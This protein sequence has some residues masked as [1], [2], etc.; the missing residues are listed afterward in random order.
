MMYPSLTATSYIWREVLMHRRSPSH[1]RLLIVVLLVGITLSSGGPII[2]VSALQGAARFAGSTQSGPVAL[3]ADSSL[4]A[5]ANTDSN[6][7][8]LFDVGGDKNQSLGEIPVGKEPQGVAMTPDGSFVYVANTL[9]GTVSVLKV[10]RNAKPPATV[11]A[12]LQ[13]GTEP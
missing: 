6:S 10:D 5:V 8:T 2:S 13:V 1:V 12:T 11:A 7:V 4:L 3:S 9:D